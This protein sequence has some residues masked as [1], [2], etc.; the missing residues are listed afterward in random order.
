[1]KSPFK[2]MKNLT[3]GIAAATLLTVGGFAN[4]QLTTIYSEDFESYDDNADFI[5]NSGWAGSTIAPGLDDSFGIVGD[6]SL[7]HYGT[8]AANQRTARTLA[9]T[10]DSTD[11]PIRLTY[12]LYDGNGAGFVRHTQPPLMAVQV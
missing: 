9:S 5:A 7:A 3:C 2:S 8:D 10:L 4:A 11:D 6:Q 12:W 1:M